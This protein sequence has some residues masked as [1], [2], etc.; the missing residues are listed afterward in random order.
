MI[1]DDVGKAM[2]LAKNPGIS[3]KIVPKNKTDDNIN[4]KVLILGATPLQMNM[5]RCFVKSV[6]AYSTTTTNPRD[7]MN[8]VQDGR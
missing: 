5:I 3:I 6:I 7:F 8:E 4:Y 2:R 1:T